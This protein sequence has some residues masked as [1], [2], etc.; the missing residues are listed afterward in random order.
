MR[1]ETRSNGQSFENNF[2]PAN[3]NKINILVWRRK[4]VWVN[5]TLDTQFDTLNC[6]VVSG[7]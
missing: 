7:T 6:Q 1:K 5:F 3:T 2:A 4:L